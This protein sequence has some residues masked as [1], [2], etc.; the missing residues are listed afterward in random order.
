MFVSRIAEVFNCSA[1]D[2]GAFFAKGG[3]ELQFFSGELFRENRA[4]TTSGALSVPFLA[5]QK[6]TIITSNFHKY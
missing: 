3:S 5:S 2:G 6:L 1:Q 4:I